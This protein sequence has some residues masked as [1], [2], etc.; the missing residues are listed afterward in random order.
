MDLAL[1]DAGGA[2]LGSVRYAFERLGV[3]PRV[4]R[5]GSELAGADR[6]VLPGVG[7]AA[8]AMQALQERGFVE[9]LRGT[10]LPVLGVCLGMQ[11]LYASSEESNTSCL[12]VMPGRVIKLQQQPHVRVPHMGWNNLQVA[13]DHWMSQG[14]IADDR[15]YF[16]H[17]YVAPVDQDCLAWTRHGV[18]FASMCV[19]ANFAGMQFHPERSSSSGAR[20]LQ[21]FLQWSPDA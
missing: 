11:L 18:E 10:R 13:R 9:V 14:L 4:V 20:L 5:H 17:S 8:P 6:I 2:N 7:A 1:V 19:R 12:G 15:A 3:N 21:R 16:V